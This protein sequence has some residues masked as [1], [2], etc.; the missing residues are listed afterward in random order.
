MTIHLIPEELH[1]SKVCLKKELAGIWF[2]VPPPSGRRKFTNVDQEEEQKRDVKILGIWDF[3]SSWKQFVPLM[4]FQ[5][6]IPKEVV[7]NTIVSVEASHE[8]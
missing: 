1:A 7:Q 4:C 2:P 6:S 8:T 5:M 3:S